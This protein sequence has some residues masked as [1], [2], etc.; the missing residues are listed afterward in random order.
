[1]AEKSD[2]LKREIQK[3]VPARDRP[4]LEAALNALRRLREIGEKLPPVDAAAVI[5]EGRTN[6]INQSEQI[7]LSV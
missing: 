3:R 4:N 5:R 2:T 7:I 1:M 6:L